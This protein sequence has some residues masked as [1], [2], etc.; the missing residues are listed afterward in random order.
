MIYIEKIQEVVRQEG[1]N[2][3]LSVVLLKLGYVGKEYPAAEDLVRDVM[4]NTKSKWVCVV[5]ENTTQVGLGTLM[6]GLNAVGYYTEVECSGLTRDPGWLHLVD[7]WVIDYVE[8]P[9]FN[10]GALR[11]SD[12]VRFTV[13]DR[14]DLTFVKEGFEQLRLFTGTRYIKLIQEE[15][16][17]VPADL[18]RDILELLKYHDRARVYVC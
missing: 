17:R 11:G 18:Q 13:K 5:G 14:G 12:M 8:S 6:K 2:Y 16:K 15:G 7:R 3:G 9:V 1:L 4:T 10:M